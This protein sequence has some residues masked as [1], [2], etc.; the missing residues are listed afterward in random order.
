MTKP[1][2]IYALV[3][4]TINSPLYIGATINPKARLSAHM[5][6]TLKDYIQKENVVIEILEKTNKKRAG[7]VEKKWTLFYMNNGIKLLKAPIQYYPKVIK[8]KYSLI[9]VALL[10]TAFNKSPQTIL[11]WIK[12]DSP[13]L[14]CDKAKKALTKP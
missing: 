9:E 14:T 4:R 12:Q 5:G 1:V 3:D 2:Y 11:R 7:I 13:L 6:T 8:S 10:A